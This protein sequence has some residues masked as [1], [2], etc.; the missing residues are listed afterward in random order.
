MD[1][2]DENEA[3][4]VMLVQ[5]YASKFG[6]TFSSRLMDDPVAKNKLMLLMAEAIMGKRG[7]VTDEDVL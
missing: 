7:A 4:V 6:I 5:Q 2:V 3:G 1:S